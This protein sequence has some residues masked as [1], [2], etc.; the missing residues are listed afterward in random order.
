MATPKIIADFE[1]Q[2]ST[3]LSVGDTSFT[4]SSATDDDGVALPAGLYYFTLDNG[5]S[6]KEYLA[7]T[8][9][10]TSVTGVL[11]VSRQGVETSGC[12]RAHRVGA[13]V[14]ITDWKTYKKYMD[15][16][17]L[18]SA[19]DAD[20]STKG[21]VEKATTAE[22]NAG[23]ATGGTGAELFVAPDA[24]TA[25]IYGVLLASLAGA[26]IPYAG[27]SAPTGFLL[28]DGSAVSRTTYSTLFSLI[29]TTYGVG[30]GSTTFNLPD[31]QGNVIV[32]LD[33]AQT[34][35]DALGETGGAKTHTLTTDEIPAH[36]HTTGVVVTG[37]G[38]TPEA[39]ATGSGTSTDTGSTGGGSAHNNLQPYIVLNYIIK[40]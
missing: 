30:D 8:L 21:V 31:I 14:I 37:T 29:G 10:G 7:G 11:S 2:L 40:T 38:S 27:S 39:T 18:V 19:P 12:A 26:V 13:S 16:I 1:A 35:F 25:S 32:G 28:C 4:L 24:L 6:N 36:T 20:T 34:E 9:S 22:I 17:A 15:E 33:S 23:T 3:A 5:N